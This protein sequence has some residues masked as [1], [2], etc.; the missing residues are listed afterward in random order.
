LIEEI[1][2]CKAQDIKKEFLSN[3]INE[4]SPLDNTVLDF[5]S[6]LGI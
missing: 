1:K 3:F 5:L 2:N 4:N 6:E